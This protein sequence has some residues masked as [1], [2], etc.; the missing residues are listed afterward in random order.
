MTTD[1]VAKI[2]YEAYHSESPVWEDESEVYK[3]IW[4]SV[5]SAVES[6]V[7]EE[8]AKVAESSIPP[9]HA[10]QNCH[11]GECVGALNA[12]LFIRRRGDS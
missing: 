6:A 5:A 12:A 10:N 7:R 3:T 1:E 8:C 9:W 2:A 4:R 11:C